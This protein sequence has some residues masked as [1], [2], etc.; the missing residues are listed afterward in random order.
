MQIYPAIDLKDGKCVRLS[1]GDFNE[2]TI[3]NE[4]PVEV[5]ISFEKKG[6]TF[7][8][9]VD[10]DGARKGSGFN[11]HIIKEIVKNVSIPIEVGGGIRNLNDIKEKI[12]LGVARIILGTSA[13][14]N[15]E[16]VKEAIDLYG[17]RIAIGIDAKN[18]NVAISG[19]E[20]ISQTKALDLAIEMKT[21]GVETIIY[22]DITKDGMMSG[23]NLETTKEIIEATKINIIT[24]GGVSSMED[25]ENVKN[26]NS[27]GVIIG[28]AL[29]TGALNLKEVLNKYEK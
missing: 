3:F 8:H 2:V 24:S 16:M 12:D 5:A 4:N 13:I 29:Y 23:P 28:K 18:G 14:T 10:L 1:Q 6:A 11:N 25:L 27:S 9:V 21:L 26:I 22:T 19:W 7:I 17:N 20:E 15:K